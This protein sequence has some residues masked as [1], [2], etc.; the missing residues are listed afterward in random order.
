MFFIVRGLRIIFSECRMKLKSYKI[1]F[2]SLLLALSVSVALTAVSN[3]GIINF[4]FII[5]KAPLELT[6]PTS[7]VLD[8]LVANKLFSQSFSDKISLYGNVAGTYSVTMTLV[9][10]LSNFDELTVKLNWTGVAGSRSVELS[11]LTP[12]VTTDFTYPSDLSAYY[13]TSIVFSG[14]PKAMGSGNIAIEFMC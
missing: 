9:G 2:V 10:D 1:V 7:F 6:G 5:S 3:L 4:A 13:T 11:L 12:S 14:L 8:D